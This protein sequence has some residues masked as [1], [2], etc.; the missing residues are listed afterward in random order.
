MATGMTNA[1]TAKDTKTKAGKRVFAG[2]RSLDE[3]V[4]GHPDA[5]R[6]LYEGGRPADLAALGEAPRGRM[7]AL[8]PASEA[9]MLLRP[10]L[11]A[12]ATDALPWKGK[13]FD[14]GGNSGVNVVFGKHMFRFHVDVG[15]SA[16][17][18]EPTL[19]LRYGEPS[20][21]NP[22]P[23]RAIVDELRSIGDGV[24]I[25]PAFFTNKGDRHLWL[26]FGLEPRRPRRA[27]GQ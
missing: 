15:P 25:G 3:L 4:G 18:G 24:A 16:I 23:V 26:W 13:V 19:V 9:F 5:L 11:R 8:G 7:L 1:A 2:V 14:H 17:D 22:W 6:A 10:V 27:G 21:K 20:Y 12:L